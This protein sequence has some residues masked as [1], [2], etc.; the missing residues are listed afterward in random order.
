MIADILT[1]EIPRKQ[2]VKLRALSGMREL[3]TIIVIEKE[4]EEMH[5]DYLLVVL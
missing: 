5:S 1:K 4:C 2:F 3:K